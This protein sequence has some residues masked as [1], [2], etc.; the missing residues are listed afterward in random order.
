[1]FGSDDVD[2]QHAQ[3]IYDRNSGK[4][5][6]IVFGH[7]HKPRLQALEGPTREPA[8]YVNTGCW[9]RLVTRRRDLTEFRAARVATRFVVD[10][11][12]GAL[13]YRLV[14]ETETD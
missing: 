10:T 6:Y 3:G 1:M 12:G 11:S 7:T 2:L 5:R 8:Y 14:Q 4:Y 13:R 9:R